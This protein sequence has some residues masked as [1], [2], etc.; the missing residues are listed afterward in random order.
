MSNIEEAVWKGN[1]SQWTNFWYFVLC[2]TGIYIPIAIWKALVTHMTVYELT[3]E[4]LLI[5]T[6]VLNKKIEE[7]ELYR[8]KDVK[9]DRP[10]LFRFVGLGNVDIATS[11]KS[12]PIVN[13]YA[14]ID[15]KGVRESIRK[16]ADNRRDAKRVREID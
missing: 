13:L 5:H 6:G 10:L 4:R 11:D 16:L 14:I 9:E 7:L 12:T 3:N 1:P 15:S 2:L 8:V